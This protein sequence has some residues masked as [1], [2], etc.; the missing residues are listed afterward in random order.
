MQQQQFYSV[1]VVVST[2][3][4]YRYRSCL[5]AYLSTYSIIIKFWLEEWTVLLKSVDNFTN[6][7]KFDPIYITYW[8]S[9]GKLFY[10]F[11]YICNFFTSKH[12]MKCSFYLYTYII[13][14][15]LAFS[16]SSLVVHSFFLGWS[17]AELSMLLWPN[18]P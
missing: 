8:I 6:H 3:H 10:Q 14:G 9:K 11:K 4:A 7:I 2:K 15:E 17:G 12:K 1:C 18:S 5:R 16:F 13:L